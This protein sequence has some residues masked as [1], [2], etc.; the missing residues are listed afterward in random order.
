[1]LVYIRTE[2][3]RA[4]PASIEA[5]GEARRIASTLGASVYAAAAVQSAPESCDEIISQIGKAGADKIV[6]VHVDSLSDPALWATRGEALVTAAARIRPLLVV[7]SGESFGRDIA[8]R[9]AARIGGV[10]LADP[11][12]QYG[13][14]GEVIFC[15]SMF[16]ATHRY[17]VLAEDIDRP[18]VV[19]LTEGSYQ[20]ALGSEDAEVLFVSTSQPASGIEIVDSADDPGSELETARVVVTAGAGASAG[21]IALCRELARSLGGEFACTQALV[22]SGHVEGDRHVGIGGRSV[23]PQLY[24]AC[25]AS[26]SAGHL[27]AVSPDAEIVAINCDARAPIFRVANYGIVGEIKDVIPEMIKELA[28]RGAKSA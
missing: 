13:S 4:T 5:L 2:G 19:T 16:G 23:S 18:L 8:P 9:L 12:V 28:Q 20:P 3:V 6:L 11:A 27:G 15:R 10:Y 25:A 1:M 24:V 21:D 7:F 14:R 26:G 17:R 22:D